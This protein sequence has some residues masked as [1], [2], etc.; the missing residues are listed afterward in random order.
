MKK[1]GTDPHFPPAGTIARISRKCGSVPG[2]LFCALLLSHG[3]VAQSMYKWVDEKG[4][5]HFSETPPPDGKAEAKKITVKPI[6]EEKPR[7]DNWKERDQQSRQSKAK[8]EV[9][10]E[11]QRMKDQQGRAQRC[12]TAQRQVDIYRNSGTVFQ[13]N[14][15]GERVFLED[16][17]RSSELRR[18]EEAVRDNC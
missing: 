16:S 18:W 13:L 15:K 3:A 5:T 11:A 9:A 10:D 12:R 6:G 14:D 4:V 2:F 17:Q 8:Q 7:A 1:P